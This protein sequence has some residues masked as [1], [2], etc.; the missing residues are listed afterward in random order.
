MTPGSALGALV[1]IVASLGFRIY[2]YFVNNYSATYGSLGAVMILLLWLYMS[3]L[4][5]L[6]GGTIN[7]KIELAA[8]Q[9]R[10]RL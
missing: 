3:G 6:L 2:L 8:R 1:W 9:E 5:Y 7:A 4:A 10:S